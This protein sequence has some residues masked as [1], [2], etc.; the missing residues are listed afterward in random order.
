MTR[1]IPRGD[2][3][4]AYDITNVTSLAKNEPFATNMLWLILPSRNHLIYSSL[5]FRNILHLSKGIVSYF[6]V[7]GWS[8]LAKAL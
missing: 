3:L 7:L 8:I 5:R 6:V 4:L 1:Q 2:V